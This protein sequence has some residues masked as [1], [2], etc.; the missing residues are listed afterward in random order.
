M[1]RT[2]AIIIGAGQA[3][4]AMSC[5]LSDRAIP[6][7]VLER[8]QIANAWRHQRWDSLRLLTPNWQ[9]RLPGYAY[10][11]NDPDGYM[12][13]PE[14]TRYLMDYAAISRAPVEEHTTV[15]DVSPSGQGYTVRTSRGEWQ[16]DVVVMATGACAVPS[17]PNLAQAIPAGIT[18]ITALDYR[19]PAQLAPG[20]V[21]VVGG[22]ASGVQLAAELRQAGHDVMISVGEHIRVPRT[23]RGR[24][25]QWW[26]DRAG[27]HTTPLSE[28]DDVQRVRR[29]PSLQLVGDRTN[30]FCD[31]NSLARRG[32]E[33]V[34]RLTAVRDGVALFSGSLANCCALSDLKMNRLLDRLDAWAGSQSVPGIEPEERFEPT[35]VP[36]SPRL[37]L[38]LTDGTFRTIVWATGARPDFS[39]LNLPVFDRKGELLHREGIVAPG[40]YVMGLS[41]M[42]RRSSALIDG[43]GRDAEELAHH[44]DISLGRRAA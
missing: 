13:M 33:V 21:L 43:V 32:V 1:K 25:I 24:D 34:G 7:L 15:L 28:I 38:D 11:G 23:Y 40:L 18:Q 3:G 16:C 10:A 26:M 41:F 44:I 9:S 12:S 39:W 29:V 6:H 14:V 37:S 2:T 31:L 8:G 5:S 19:N 17:V 4:L 35:T 27:I 42:R 36:A 20:P 22:S 30:R